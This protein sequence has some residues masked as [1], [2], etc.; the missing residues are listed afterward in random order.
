MAILELVLRIIVKLLE[1]LCKSSKSNNSNDRSPP[2]Q[3]TGQSL[4]DHTTQSIL[5]YNDKV[6]L[7]LD[8]I[9]QNHNE[10]HKSDLQTIAQLREQ[11][12]ELEIE[13]I[14][15]KALLHAKNNEE[16]VRKGFEVRRETDE[17][18]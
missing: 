2:P 7:T 15:L 17:E 6:R 16:F 4:E 5:N 14:R 12:S 9:I 1:Y 10:L 8:K 3:Q 13:V 18:T 11:I